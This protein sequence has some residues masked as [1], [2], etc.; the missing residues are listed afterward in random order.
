MHHLT[1][2]KGFRY[3]ILCAKICKLSPLTDLPLMSRVRGLAGSGPKWLT[4]MV[5]EELNSYVTFL[6]SQGQGAR[7]AAAEKSMLGMGGSIRHPGSQ[8]SHCGGSSGLLDRG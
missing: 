4:Y 2:Q 7:L 5:Q 1:A 3:A 8:L 6:G